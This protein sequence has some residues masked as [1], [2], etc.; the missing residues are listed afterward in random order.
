MATPFARIYPR[1]CCHGIKINLSKL[2]QRTGIIN[3]KTNEAKIRIMGGSS[4][5]NLI[6][7]M[8]SVF[9]LY[10]ILSHMEHN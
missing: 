7:E 1:S 10:Q 8:L 4:L 6:E 2:V 5:K 9:R 3:S